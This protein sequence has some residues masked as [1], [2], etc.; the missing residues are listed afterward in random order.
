MQPI[1][2]NDFTG[3]VLGFLGGAITNVIGWDTVATLVTA[4][5]CGMLGALG[6][7]LIKR[8]SHTYRAKRNEKSS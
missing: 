5:V 1:Q 4:F 6:Q 7:L 2:N 8:I 3:P